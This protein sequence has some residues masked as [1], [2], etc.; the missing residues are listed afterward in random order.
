M[1]Y[2]Q[3]LK[4]DKDKGTISFGVALNQIDKINH[5]EKMEFSIEIAAPS[6]RVWNTLWDDK[7][8]RDWGNIIDEGQYMVGEIKEGNE[9]QFISGES[10]YG[11]TSLIE[12]LEPNKFVLFRQMADTKDRGEQKREK[13]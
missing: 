4:Y 1:V 12:K 9:V 8:F 3:V 11:V 7:A 13:E 6:Q 10:G 5:M 2:S